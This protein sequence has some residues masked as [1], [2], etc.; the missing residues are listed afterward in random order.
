MNVMLDVAKARNVTASNAAAAVTMRPVRSRPIATDAV[1]SPGPVVLLLDAREQEDLVVHRQPERDA[2]H[3]DRRGGVGQAGRREVQ[4]PAPWPSWKTQTI[5]PNV[6]VSDSRFNAIAF[7]GT[8]T[9]PNMRNSSTNV[10]SAMIPAASGRR[11]PMAAL[12]S[13]S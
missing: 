11:S 10:A 5:A 9:D 13:T 2:E 6:A 12:E 7:S 8:T 1:L 3:Q 4:D